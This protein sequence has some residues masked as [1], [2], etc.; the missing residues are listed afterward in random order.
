[1]RCPKQ[2]CCWA[3]SS[4][5]FHCLLLV[6]R[7]CADCI[8]TWLQRHDLVWFL[9]TLQVSSFWFT[10]PNH[11]RIYSCGFSQYFHKEFFLIL[12]SASLLGNS[13]ETKNIFEKAVFPQCLWPETQSH[14]GSSAFRFK[15]MTFLSQ[16]DSTQIG[17][18][19]V[20]VSLSDFSATQ[21]LVHL[22]LVW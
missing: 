11:N 22:S 4:C 5:C 10:L 2:A 1:M 8:W 19:K 12:A 21:F 18:S 17:S 13:F 20:C 6:Y 16:F 3:L 14:G 7:L 9:F 15:C